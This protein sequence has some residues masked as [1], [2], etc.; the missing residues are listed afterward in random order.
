[1]KMNEKV[2]EKTIIALCIK[3]GIRFLSMIP[4]KFFKMER[5]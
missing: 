5:I 2:G 4:N 1:M 3:G